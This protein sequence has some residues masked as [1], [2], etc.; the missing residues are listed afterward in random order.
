MNLTTSQLSVYN[1][2]LGMSNNGPL[3]EANR[4]RILSVNFN[5]FGIT[6]DD[7]KIAIRNYEHVIGCIF[8]VA[9]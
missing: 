2:L 7:K 4:A 5:K 3:T 6:E 1:I 8:S 9:A